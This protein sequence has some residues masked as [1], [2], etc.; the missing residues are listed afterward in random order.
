MSTSSTETHRSDWYRT[1]DEQTRAA[2]QRLHDVRPGV[3]AWVLA[4]F[5]G[6]WVATAWAMAMVPHWAVYAVGYALIGAV[7]HGFAV[8][9]HEAVHSNLTRIPKLDRW[10]GFLIGLPAMAPFT[11]YKL[12]HLA[13]HRYTRT[14]NDPDEIHNFSSK[15]ALLSIA[16]YL[17]LFGGTL[18]YFFAYVPFTAWR[19]AGAKQRRDIAVEYA[20]MAVIYGSMVLAAIRF[21]YLIT[22]VH[23][24]F[25]PILVATFYGNIRGWAE[26]MLTIP[27]HPLTETR[28]VTSNP[29]LGFLNLNLNY[30][31][32]HH[33]FPAMPWY[34]LPRLHTLLLPDYRR[35]GA[36]IYRSYLKFL[37]DAFI[38]GVHGLAPKR[39]GEAAVRV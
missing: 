15:R 32:E 4:G 27:G 13:H 17:W 7:V 2:I 23:Y 10:L 26:H 38:I 24:W 22:L 9:M 11:P 39:R 3:N 19:M 37:W 16:F 33:L 35:A 25:I 8:M 20:I 1:V 12:Q 36:F 30:H 28:T 6:I 18:W 31:L 14:E 29:V 21:G 5:V 34:N